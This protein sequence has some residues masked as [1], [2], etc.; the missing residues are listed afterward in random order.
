MNLANKLTILRVLLIPVFLIFLFMPDIPY[1]YFFA[2]A[3][4][5]FASITDALDGY[6]ARKYNLITNF[7]KFL[8]PLADK[9]LVMAAIIAFVQLDF[10][11]SI[12]VI[13]ILTREFMVTSLR[14]VANKE[15]GEVIAAA[16]MGKIKTAVTMVSIVA[17]LVLAGLEIN[18]LITF[19]FDNFLI[20]GIL[21]WL[22]TILT[23]ISG[24]QYLM[25]YK[26]FINPK[27]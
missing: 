25:S 20:Y 9:V 24:F 6:I 5:A 7:G 8:D 18:L 2:L 21:I 19:P 27:E 10:I 26:N 16:F 11:S 22:S 15:G 1:N 14:L 3:V 12:P 4:F 23:I 13:I 17:I